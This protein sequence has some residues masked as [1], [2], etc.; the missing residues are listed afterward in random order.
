MI[1][2]TIVVV[3]PM[4]LSLSFPSFFLLFSFLSCLFSGLISDKGQS[5]SED[6]ASNAGDA[7][8]MDD[9]PHFP[10]LTMNATQMN[11][12]NDDY[13]G[14]LVEPTRKVEKVF[15][16]SSLM[17]FILFVAFRFPSLTTRWPNAL[18]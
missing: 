2:T 3:W 4:F 6:E 15:Q 17:P 16:E 18:T 14:D 13:A 7:M 1:A 10:D 11:T 12:M 8:D 5:I 9:S